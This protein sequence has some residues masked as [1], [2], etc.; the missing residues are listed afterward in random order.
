MQKDIPIPKIENIDGDTYRLVEEYPV[1]FVL[2]Y[3]DFQFA[4]PPDFISDLASIPRPLRIFIDRASLGIIAPL[5]HDYLCDRRGKIVSMSSQNIELTRY[6]VN[7]IFLIAMLLDGISIR[8]SV[9]AFI[10][11]S[12]GAPKW[13]I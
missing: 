12:I 9:I 5:I 1:K 4:V 3:R 8:R 11:V 2:W 7:F 13:K 10:G 6:E